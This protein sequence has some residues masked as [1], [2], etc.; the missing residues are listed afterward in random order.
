MQ[1]AYDRVADHVRAGA[2]GRADVRAIVLDC[3]DLAPLRLPDED[4]DALDRARFELLGAQVASLD[5]RLAPGERREDSGRRVVDRRL[6]L[7][8]WRL[9]RCQRLAAEPA[10]AVRE[11]ASEDRHA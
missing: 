3:E 6:A 1:G 5:A 2:Q 8:D 10:L 9:C 4:V 7:R 11:Q